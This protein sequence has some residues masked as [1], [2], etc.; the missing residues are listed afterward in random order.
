VKYKT[1]G[2]F[3]CFTVNVPIGCSVPGGYA[4]KVDIYADFITG[5]L[6][7][8]LSYFLVQAVSAILG[9]ATFK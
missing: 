5:Y 6:K 1:C 3:Y 4:L 2:D 9:D 7:S 8:K